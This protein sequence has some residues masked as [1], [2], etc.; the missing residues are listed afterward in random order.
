M[1]IN[2]N[3]LHKEFIDLFS[4]PDYLLNNWQMC[5]SSMILLVNEE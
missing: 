1:Q 3:N 4:K 5:D 2:G